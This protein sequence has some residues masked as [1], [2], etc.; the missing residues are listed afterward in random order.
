MDSGSIVSILPASTFK[1]TILDNNLILYAANSTQIRTFGSRTI[2]V[3]FNLRRR[4]TWDFIVADISTPIIGA[5]FLAHFDLL[6]DLKNQQ[7][8]DKTTRRTTQGEILATQL[9]GISTMN[10][11]TP[12]AE[13]LKE[14]IDV[15]KPPVKPTRND[16]SHNII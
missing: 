11:S 5:D 14:Y 4:L 1:K 7:L 15:T 8:I 16:T 12:F 2:T 6:I 9:H 3:D 13:L 10:S